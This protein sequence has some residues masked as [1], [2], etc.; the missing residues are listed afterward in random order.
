MRLLGAGSLAGTGII[1]G[2][3]IEVA[4]QT[5]RALLL[6]PALEL[7]PGWLARNAGA[8]ALARIEVPHQLVNVERLLGVFEF[9]GLLVFERVRTNPTGLVVASCF[10]VLGFV[11][12]R[13]NVSVTGMESAAGVRYVPSWMELTVSLGLV[14][15]GF[16]L[17]ALAVRYLPV[18]PESTP[19]RTS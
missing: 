8:A 9:V 5:L 2:V 1:H 18:F 6:E 4:Q 7:A 12:S 11:M 16:A 13:L 3:I 10:A 19:R 17:F 14:A 15:L